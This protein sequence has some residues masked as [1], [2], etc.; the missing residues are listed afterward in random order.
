MSQPPNTKTYHYWICLRCDW[1]NTHPDPRSV[2]EECHKCFKPAELANIDEERAAKAMGEYYKAN[3]SESFR[4]DFLL[5]E[6]PRMPYPPPYARDVLAYLDFT[7]GVSAFPSQ[8][9]EQRILPP[10]L[11]SEVKYDTSKDLQ[12]R[13]MDASDSAPPVPRGQITTGQQKLVTS[14]YNESL[15]QQGPPPQPSSP[16]LNPNTDSVEKQ[17]KFMDTRSSK[18]DIGV[19]FGPTVA[20]S[21]DE[22]AAEINRKR[23]AS[24]GADDGSTLDGSSGGGSGGGSSTQ[25]KKRH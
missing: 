11:R 24:P 18:S 12:N 1:V 17:Q 25:R 5:T 21:I 20:A 14:I 23:V 16:A 13:V 15:S 7:T 6:P 2:G 3:K 4:Q 8:F 19:R 9:W 22:H 10:N